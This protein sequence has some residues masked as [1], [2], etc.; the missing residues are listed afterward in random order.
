MAVADAAQVARSLSGVQAQD[1]PAAILALRPRSSGLTADDV[2]RALWQ[3]R[4]LVRTWCFRGTLH[5]LATEDFGWLL[6][7][8]GPVFVAR[9]RRRFAELG[10]DEDTSARGAKALRSLLGS[11][12][13]LTRAVI[14]EHLAT[15]GVHLEGQARPYLLFRAA[16]EGIIWYGP[17]QGAEPS[18]VLVD[19]WIERGQSLPRDAA[20]ADLAR[21]HLSAYGP[22]G[23]ADLA[24]W[25]GLSMGDARAGWTSIGGE[26]IEV[27]IDG[28]PAWMLREQAFWLDTPAEGPAV[29]RLLPAFD[30]YLLGHA[31]RDLIVAPEHARRVNKGSGWLHPTL[32]VDG[33]VL[34]T[35]SGKR[36]A[37]RLVVVVTP[38][39]E[40]DPA[41]QPW[42]EAEAAD[43]GRFLGLGAT[44]G[45]ATP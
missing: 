29:V 6:P 21:R 19:D 2:R 41:I 22:A 39:D 28:T 23:P 11:R 10:L 37:K 15:H 18:Y 3:E 43:V 20:L 34:G 45:V 33:R 36:R 5:L 4:S 14:V 44:L 40:I 30:T 42:L 27:E 31:K 35:W 38:F 1:L 7:L 26:V 24:A 13:P 8:L 12:G 16:L 17:N 25:S 32:A 9:S